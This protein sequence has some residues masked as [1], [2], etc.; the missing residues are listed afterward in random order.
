MAS[1]ARAVLDHT[2][3][4]FYDTISPACAAAGDRVAAD[5]K[6]ALTR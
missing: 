6:E 2:T 4:R 3:V 1:V 5:L